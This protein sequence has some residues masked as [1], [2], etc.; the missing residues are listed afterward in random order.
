[1]NFNFRSLELEGALLVECNSYKDKRG[2][3]SEVYRT[4]IFD[5]YNI[6]PFVQENYSCS[7][8]NVIRGLHYQAKPM[9][10]GK[11]VSCPHGQIYDVIVDVRRDSETRGKWTAILLENG[12]A[13]LWIPPGFAHGF[14][15]L[16]ETANVM[17]R[18]TQYYRNTYDRNIRWNDSDIGIRWPIKD[19]IVSEKDARA[20]LFREVV[21]RGDLL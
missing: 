11:L 7:V 10:V 9:E 16:S 6:G 13:M 8:K 19:S 2:S 20:P 5:E 12:N 17:Y 15:V 3:F 18:Q 21:E 1:M 4:D 14:C